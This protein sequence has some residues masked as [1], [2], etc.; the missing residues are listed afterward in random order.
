MYLVINQNHQHFILTAFLCCHAK[1]HIKHKTKQNKK[2][3][4]K[5]MNTDFQPLS[6]CDSKTIRLQ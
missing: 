4:K 2:N 3:A 1:N 6:G 5:Q